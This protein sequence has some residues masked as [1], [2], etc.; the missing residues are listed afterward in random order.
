MVRKLPASSFRTFLKMEK[1]AGIH[2]YWMN[3]PNASLSRSP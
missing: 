2:E 3:N 1:G